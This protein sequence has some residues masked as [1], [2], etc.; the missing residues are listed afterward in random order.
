MLIFFFKTKKKGQAEMIVEDYVGKYVDP[1]SEEDFMDILNR[2]S[3][4]DPHT[5]DSDIDIDELDWCNNEVKRIHNLYKESKKMK[6]ALHNELSDL[7]DDLQTVLDDLNTE[8]SDSDSDALNEICK[9]LSRCIKMLIDYGF[10]KAAKVMKG[11]DDIADSL[12]ELGFDYYAEQIWDIIAPLRQNNFNESKKSNIRRFTE[13]Y[14]DYED[15]FDN[16][17]DSSE[18]LSSMPELEDLLYEAIDILEDRDYEFR[19]KYCTVYRSKYGKPTLYVFY[20]SQDGNSDDVEHYFIKSLRKSNFI[21]KAKDLGYT[22]K[23]LAGCR[24]DMR[25]SDINIK[26]YKTVKPSKQ[27]DK[28]KETKKMNKKVL[29]RI[30]VKEAKKLKESAEFKGLSEYQKGIIY[31]MA[32]EDYEAGHP[33]TPEDALDW[34]E[35]GEEES[36]PPELAKEAADYYFEA[37]DD[38]R[39]NDNNQYDESVKSHNKPIK[40]HYATMHYS[41]IP[42]YPIDAYDDP[43][44]FCGHLNHYLPNKFHINVG[45]ELFTAGTGGFWVYVSS[46]YEMFRGSVVYKPDDNKIY[47]TINSD[48][49]ELGIITI[50]EDTTWDELGDKVAETVGEA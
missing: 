33:F 10:S 7:I 15:W 24:G 41:D 1:S 17:I 30:S 23:V 21:N 14:E 12:N 28:V 45:G 27:Q 16:N 3:R 32:D 20:E 49:A 8:N 40:E 50:D 25:A 4:N 48:D 36:I 42:E 9:S 2:Y 26:A 43:I 39:E 38:I 19:C 13:D 11:L 22:V 34:F 46:E 44:V 6:E 5:Y 18:V 35:S 37:F 31:D 47:F 29:G